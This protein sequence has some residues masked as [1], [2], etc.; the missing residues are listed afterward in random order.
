[1]ISVK[2]NVMTI[3]EKKFEFEA[4]ISAYVEYF[5]LIIL[6]LDYKHDVLNNIY[7]IDKK[8]LTIKWQVEDLCHYSRKPRPFTSI[9]IVNNNI[10]AW[11]L[12]GLRYFLDPETGEII[13]RQYQR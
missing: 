10:T 6:V 7:A 11:D 9:R 2:Q 5:E 1:M 12:F 3:D 4:P 13:F 8:F